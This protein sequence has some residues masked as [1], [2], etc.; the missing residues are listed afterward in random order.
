M[1]LTPAETIVTILAVA[2]GAMVTRFLPF[3]VFPEHRQP[4][5]VVSYLGRVL[6]PAM[7]GLLVVYCL[8]GVTITAKPHGLPELISIGVII[9]LHWWRSNVLLSIAG[10]TVVYMLLVQYV[11][12]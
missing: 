2:L 3:L 12:L 4:P 7:M 6:P 5:Q 1:P 10:G 9:L 11:F 8:K